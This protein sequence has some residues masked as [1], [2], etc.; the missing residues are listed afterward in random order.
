MQFTVCS[1]NLRNA[2]ADDGKDSW[3]HRQQ[4]L[5]QTLHALTPDII[6][7][8]ECMD[9][10]LDWV[11]NTFADYTIMPGLPYGNHGPYEYAALALRNDLFTVTGHGN[12]FLSDT[13][14]VQSRSW[15]CTWT[16]VANW[17]TVTHI[18][19]GQALCICNTHLDHL[20]AQSRTESIHVIATQLAPLAHL[21]TIIMGDFNVA[22]ASAAHA[23]LRGYG[24]VDSWQ[25]TGHA[26]GPGVMTF[27]GFKGDRWPS[28]SG[29]PDDAR[30]DWICSRD[31]HHLLNVVAAYICKDC[32][33]S[34]RYPSDHYF[35]TAQFALTTKK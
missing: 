24:F 10:Q 18:P 12:C 30:I 34:G 7:V 31:P 2:N 13:P 33:A 14:H 21:P 16:R 17:V 1:A 22:P 20:G 32:D 8:Q 25:A 19:S 29:E 4:L 3:P 26:D 9:A 28:I 6:G 27:H 23:A 15:D 11:R 35:V 5:A